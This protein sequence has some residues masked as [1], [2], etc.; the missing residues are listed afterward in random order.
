MEKDT[1]SM[2]IYEKMLKVTDEMPVVQKNLDIRVGGSANYKAVSERDILDAVRPIEIRYGIYSYPYSRKI[3]ASETL[4][5]TTEYNDR[6]VK[7][8]S[9][10][11]RV[12]TVYRFV[13]IDNPEQ[14]VDIT[15]YGDGIDTSDKATGKAMTYADKYALMKAYKIST[16]DDPDKEASEQ[17]ISVVEKPMLPDNQKPQYATE[18]QVEILSNIYTGDNLTK[19]LEANSI[20]SIDELTVSKASELIS[21]CFEAKKNKIKEKEEK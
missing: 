13:N 20:K 10:F 21:K 12:E 7:N 19:L 6:I 1:K 18:K 4:V 9:L 17:N 8:S 3:I 14:Y 15:T 11:L 5:K 2:N 16:G